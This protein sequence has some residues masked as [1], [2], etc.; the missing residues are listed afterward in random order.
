M[1]FILRIKRWNSKNRHILYVTENQLRKI[2]NRAIRHGFS[3]ISINPCSY[4]HV[5]NLH[6]KNRNI[7]NS[8]FSEVKMNLLKHN[9]L[10]I[11]NNSVSL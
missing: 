2:K 4:S 6:K 7:A 9:S 8:F 11:R 3:I 5:Y 1:L 10:K